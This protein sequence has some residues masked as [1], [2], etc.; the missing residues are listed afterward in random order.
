MKKTIQYTI[1]QI[2]QAAQDFAKTI[3]KAS[4]VTFAGGLGAGKTTFVGS[5]LRHW[6]VSMAVTSPTF[7]YLNIYELGDGRVA[8]HFDL[9]RLKS[10]AEFEAAGFFEYLYQPGSV[11]LI[12]WPEIIES[13]LVDDACMAVVSVVGNNER[14]ITYDVENKNR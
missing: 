7:A 8:Y 14:L 1:D 11:A 5:L 4:V 10:L 13:V 12:E 3:G 6:G 2:D 9:Y